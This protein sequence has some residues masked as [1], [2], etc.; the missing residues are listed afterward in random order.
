MKHIKSLAQIHL[1]DEVRIQILV[2]VI[3]EHYSFHFTIFCISLLEFSAF[4]PI[5]LLC[6]KATKDNL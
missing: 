5:T 1:A 3:P 6:L 4:M 2:Y